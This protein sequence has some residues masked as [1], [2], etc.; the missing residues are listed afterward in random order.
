MTGSLALQRLQPDS[1]S[2][3][4]EDTVSSGGDRRSEA[5]ELKSKLAV[6]TFI[7]FILL[8]EGTQKHF[9]QQIDEDAHS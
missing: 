6:A 9:P 1:D 3:D 8:K 5:V 7:L 2:G 4:D